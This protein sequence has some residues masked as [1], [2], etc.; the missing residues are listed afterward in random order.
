MVMMMLGI[1]L[2]SSIRALWKSYQQRHLGQVGGMDYGVRI[3][4]IGI[5]NTSR[6]L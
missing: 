6:D 1:T 2:D 4:P 3:L 5:R